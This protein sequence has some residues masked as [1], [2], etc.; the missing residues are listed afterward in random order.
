[1]TSPR[2]TLAELEPGANFVRRHI[3]PSNEETAE[4]LA[5]LGA[6][7]LENFIAKVVRIRSGPAGHSIFRH[8]RPNAPRCHICA[9]GRPQRS[10]R[11]D[12]RHGY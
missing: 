8:K 4:M 3:G 12:A 5:S 2:Q 9:D 7:S 6:K 10:L 1:M 11:V